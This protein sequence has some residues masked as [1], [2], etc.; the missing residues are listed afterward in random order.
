MQR[1]LATTV[2][3]LTAPFVG[4][5]LPF[6]AAAQQE[7]PLPLTPSRWM[8]GGTVMM[9]SAAGGADVSLVALGLS[10]GTLR[11]NALGGDLAFVVLPR[12][13]IAGVLVV[14]VRANLA[15]PLV[16]GR[17]ALL[18]PSAGVSLLGAA[19]AGGVGGLPGLN[20]TMAMIFF[21]RPLSDPGPAHG[22]RIA[23]A[24]HRFGRDG[25]G[26]VQMLEIGF[27]RR[28]R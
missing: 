11:P 22:L 20:G 9:P 24:M 4:A 5:L 15:L 27:V 14:G 6:S 2:R 28:A 18:V 1:R 26:G 21:T 8:L 23:L 10:A 13:V 16:V 12:A 25:E 19:G 3:L 7:D 17:N